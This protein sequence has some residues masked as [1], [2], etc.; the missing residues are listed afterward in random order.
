[1]TLGLAPLSHKFRDFGDRDHLLLLFALIRD[2]AILPTK[3]TLYGTK[4]IF[5]KFTLKNTALSYNKQHLFYH[6]RKLVLK[7][8]DLRYNDFDREV[9]QYVKTISI[10]YYKFTIS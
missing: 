9:L 7:F 10:F 8:I 6:F 1:M 3:C 4:R 5:C 2:D